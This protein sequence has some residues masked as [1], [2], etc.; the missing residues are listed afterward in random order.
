MRPRTAY[1]TY[2]NPQSVNLMLK[3]AALEKIDALVSKKN[4]LNIRQADNPNDIQWEN[5]KKRPKVLNCIHIFWTAIKIIG[6]ICL[7]LFVIFE[8][9]CYF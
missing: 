8:V 9:K 6:C 2:Q 1:I 4:S 3:L 7:T 5:I